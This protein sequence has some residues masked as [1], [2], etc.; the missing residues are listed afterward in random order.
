[1]LLC[2]GHVLHVS[3]RIALAPV[4]IGYACVSGQEQYLGAQ[5][6]ALRAAGCERVF[7]DTASGELAHRPGL[8]KGLLV[9]R[10]S[11]QLVVTRLGRL[12]RSLIE[13]SH[14]L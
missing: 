3:V 7:I 14:H 1:M 6:D 11:D 12:G 2:T 9:A 5:Q 4:R 13:L 10:R 8:D